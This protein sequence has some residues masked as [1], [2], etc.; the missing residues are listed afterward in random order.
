MRRQDIRPRVNGNER[1]RAIQ[2]LM[3]LDVHRFSAQSRLVSV[4][5]AA[6]EAWGLSL[7]A[8]PPGIPSGKR[9]FEV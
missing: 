5:Y 2:L 6:Q 9:I 3:T 8:V 4:A 1:L 7:K